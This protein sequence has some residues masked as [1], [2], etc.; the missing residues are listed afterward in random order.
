M[1]CD[2]SWKTCTIQNTLHKTTIFQRS[3]PTNYRLNMKKRNNIMLLINQILTLT[4]PATNAPQ[5]N[6]PMSLGVEINLQQK[7]YISEK[8]RL[9]IQLLSGNLAVTC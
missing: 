1:S 6:V 5:L 8:V 7:V 2:Y 3:Q 9:K 4:I